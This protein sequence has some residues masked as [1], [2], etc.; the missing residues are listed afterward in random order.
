MPLSKQKKTQFHAK[1]TGILKSYEKV[2][3]V[4]VTNVGSKQMNDTRASMR[5]VAEMLMGKNTMMKK[6]L[7]DFVEANP[8]HIWQALEEKL[9]GNCGFIF[10]NDELVKVRD[11]IEA[12]RVPA[13]ARVGAIA[14][15]DVTVP[16]G[17]T[18]C[19][20]GQ[21]NFFQTLQIPTKIVK[22]QIEITSDVGLIK[23]GQ[24]IEAGEVTL[25]NK[26]NIRPFSYGLVIS[27]IF[28]YGAF[29]SAKVLDID[30]AY[31][32]E[33]FAKASRAVA[34]LSFA[35][36]HPTAASVPHSVANAFKTI[37]A[38]TVGLENFSFAKA[39]EYKAAL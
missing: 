8:G 23:V 33:A 26:L 39:D 32:A 25:L 13:P 11:F 18:G 10:T 24:K 29:F 9:V 34:C 21:T 22:G 36:G 1:M 35:L 5:G 37:V 2:F 12:N 6:V 31:L 4:D 7:K 15:I 17:P 19:D 16:A 28:D 30:D 38:I 14:P 20:P 3:I 27:E